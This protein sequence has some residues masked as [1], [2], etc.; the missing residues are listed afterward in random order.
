MSASSNAE[1]SRTDKLAGANLAISTAVYLKQSEISQSL[2]YVAKHAEHQSVH[3]EHQSAHAEYQSIHAEFQSAHAERQTE[4][5]ETQTELLIRIQNEKEYEKRVK[6]LVFLIK[7]E[8]E[9]INN[10]SN[11]FERWLVTHS[12]L[13]T[14]NSYDFSSENLTD[15]SDKIFFEDTI[16][17]LRRNIEY[18]LSKSEK[19]KI[20]QILSFSITLKDIKDFYDFMESLQEKYKCAC[21]DIEFEYKNASITRKLINFILTPNGK[22]NELLEVKKDFLAGSD[23]IHNGLESLTNLSLSK[24][25]YKEE[26]EV[27]VQG[28]LGDI[29][30][31]YPSLRDLFDWTVRPGYAAASKVRA[32]TKPNENQFEEQIYTAPQ[33]ATETYKDIVLVSVDGGYQIDG[34]ASKT[35]KTLSAAKAYID[36]KH[37]SGAAEAS[38]E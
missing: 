18:H 12:F 10:I 2:D 22:E 32:K 11:N 4:I 27:W 37:S 38:S 13:N 3:A 30:S 24:E 17:S 6:H 15:I 8:S 31:V 26:I 7:K 9:K 14:V 29:L 23:I 35:F 19:D 16:K 20:S 28:V 36:L 5:L 25:G 21:D 34:N 1:W 33:A